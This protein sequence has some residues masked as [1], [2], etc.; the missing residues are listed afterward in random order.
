M[1]NKQTWNPQSKKV[2][3][4]NKQMTSVYVYISPVLLPGS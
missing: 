3:S 1:K 4:M 2:D